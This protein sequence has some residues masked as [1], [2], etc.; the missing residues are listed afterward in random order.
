MRIDSTV[1][2]G[3]VSIT[4]DEKVVD[5]RVRLLGEEHPDTITAR[6]NLAQLQATPLVHQDT[7]VA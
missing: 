6:A 5:D 4:I 7:D 2:R 1:T 3:R